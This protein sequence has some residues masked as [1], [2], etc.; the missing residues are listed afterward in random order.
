MHTKTRKM[1]VQFFMDVQFVAM[2][3]IINF[4]LLIYYYKFINLDLV[5]YS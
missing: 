4:F 3:C 5:M 1:S 2:S